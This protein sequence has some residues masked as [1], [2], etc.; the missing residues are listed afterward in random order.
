MDAHVRPIGSRLPGYVPPAA[1]PPAARR[2]AGADEA[3]RPPLLL[4]AVSRSTQAVR[5]EKLAKV[6][7]RDDI[8]E[9]AALLA[10]ADEEAR[11]GILTKAD[12]RGRTVLL[13][14]AEL[15]A[16]RSVALLVREG[17]AL[18]AVTPSGLSAPFVAAEHGDGRIPTFLLEDARLRAR[19]HDGWHRRAA[20]IEARLLEMRTRQPNAATLDAVAAD[21]CGCDHEAFKDAQSL[22]KLVGHLGSLRGSPFGVDLEFWTCVEALQM[23]VRALLDVAVRRIPPDSPADL[24]PLVRELALALETLRGQR[25]I[26][27]M[28]NCASLTARQSLTEL[29]AE[30]IMQRLGPND[31]YVVH[32]WAQ[33]R[34]DPAAYHS[35]YLTLERRGANVRLFLD[36]AGSGL[37]RHGAQDEAL[38][39]PLQCN[40]VLPEDEKDLRGLLVQFLAA[41]SDGTKPLAAFYEPFELLQAKHVA[42]HGVEAVAPHE[43]DRPAPQRQFAA[44]CTLYNFV[45]GLQRRLGD[46]LSRS[47]LSAESDYAEQRLFAELNPE[48]LRLLRQKNEKDLAQMLA[49]LK[50]KKD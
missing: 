11:V 18:E 23:H 36:N 4:P 38:I 39:P 37:E 48:R 19:L 32:C 35:F 47:V 29:E 22:Q 28:S 14:A 43:G 25:R 45:T 5:E 44:N 3:A 46:E 2:A 41:S 16:L 50:D 20:S 8:L 17:A 49:K 21:L 1:V 27:A 9:L 40:L 34:K 33:T 12:E 13:R 26:L 24:G 15:G 6:L 7:L 42:A 10:E 30:N 31:S